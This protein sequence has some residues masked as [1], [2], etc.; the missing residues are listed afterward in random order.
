MSHSSDINDSLLIES[1]RRLRAGSIFLDHWLN[2]QEQKTPNFVADFLISTQKP[3]DPARFDVPSECHQTSDID[4]YLR[5]LRPQV[6]AHLLVRDLYFQCGL[7]EVVTTMTRFADRAVAQLVA[8]HH[9]QLLARY[10]APIGAESN[11]EQYLL[12]IAM[13]KQGGAELNVSS[14]IDLVFVYPEEG[15]TEKGLSNHEFF[16]KLG[17][18]LFNSLSEVQAEGFVFRV[19]TALRPNGG[20]GPLVCGFN[21]L[22][23]YFYTQGREWERYAWQKSRAVT[24]PV[25]AIAELTEIVRPF[26]YRR[27]LDFAVIQHL[28]EMHHQIRTEAQRQAHQNSRY[29]DSVKI[30]H[31]GIRQIEFLAQMPQLLRAGRTPELQLK[32]TRASLRTLEKLNIMTK[33]TVAELLAAYDFL[34]RVEHAIQFVEDA[35]NHYLPAD[36][37]TQKRLCDLLAINDY[38]QFLADLNLHRNIVAQHFHALFDEPD[39]AQNSQEVNNEANNADDELASAASIWADL[40]AHHRIAHAKE[41]VQKKIYRLTQQVDQYMSAQSKDKDRTALTVKR[42][43]EFI[44]KIVGRPVYL[45]LLLE[46]PKVL[47]KLLQLQ[48]AS[49]WATHYLNQHPILLDDLITPTPFDAA[50]FTQQLNKVI[51]YHRD[52]LEQQLIVLREHHQTQLFALLLRDLSGELTVEQL[53]DELSLLADI[54]IAVTLQLAWQLLPKTHLPAPKIAVIGYGKLGSK[55][56]SYSSDLDLVFVYDDADD[57]AAYHYVKL[58]QKFSS[59]MTTPTSSGILFE[60]DLALRPN[61]ASGVMA[62]SLNAFTNYHQ[63]SAWLWEHQALT[64]ARCCAGDIAVCARV[65]QVRNEVLST[66]RD[67]AI[68]GAELVAMRAKMRAANPPSEHEFHLKHDRGGMIDLEFIVQFWILARP[69]PDLSKNVGNIALL[70]LAAQLGYVSQDSAENC[71]LAYRALRH[72]HHQLALQN[73]TSGRVARTQRPLECARIEA[74]W[75]EVLGA[76]AV[77]SSSSDGNVTALC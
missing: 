35:Q 4:S 66:P 17:Q 24:G 6:I 72:L 62:C 75:D 21:M 48:Q 28:R 45:S 42:F 68:F 58:V 8:H 41:D 12:V 44:V 18:R 1:T 39:V 30:G 27:Y 60:V 61:G 32:S 7:D 33:E 37:L 25:D 3:F 64:R 50:L 67:A 57:S 70:R 69:H 14:D 34:R 47:N 10:G 40:Y 55:E 23:N 74:L 43:S 73:D 63:N 13:G 31:G 11:S 56:L 77:S 26:V 38:A 29:T 52:D 51:T 22:Q 76:Y 49:A 20:S 2:Q 71:V 36:E 15:E 59:L 53:S 19:D 46:Y 5:R 9:Q 54:L 65:D 16:T